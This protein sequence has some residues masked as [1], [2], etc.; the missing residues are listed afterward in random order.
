L[1][2]NER[3][4]SGK[5]EKASDSILNE[6]PVHFPGLL[7]AL[8]VTKKAAKAGFDWEN[9]D[10]VFKKIDEETAELKK[11]IAADN[12]DAI[13]SEIGDLLFA[14]V[15]LARKLDIEPE[16][17]LKRTNRKFRRRFAFIEKELRS[18][19]SGFERSDLAS[20]DVLWEKAKSSGL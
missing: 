3:A 4:A 17:A 15:N 12:P 16:T 5:I 13:E 10:Q 1:K 8:K 11:E 20:L 7:E 9:A 2:A 6:V 19:N 14:V 18:Q